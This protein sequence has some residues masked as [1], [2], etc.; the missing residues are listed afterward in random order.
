MFFFLHVQHR[1]D[2][3]ILDRIKR[4]EFMGNG[5]LVGG[6]TSMLIALT[7]A[8]ARYGWSSWHML[9]P[10][11]LASRASFLLTVSHLDENS[12]TVEWVGYMFTGPIGA[13]LLLNARLPGF[14][15][16]A[17]EADQAAATG[18]WNSIRTLG[19]IRGVAAPTA[20]FVNQV[21][22]LVNDGA[23]SSPLTTGL[24]YV[25][26]NRKSQVM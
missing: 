13:G 11:P 2:S 18:S 14:R 9:A 22:I 7:Y 3:S 10:R 15:A 24:L 20:I 6:T 4:V 8:G 1:R 19:S 25:V 21:D 26:P 17:S 5:I 23:I 12:P 16:P